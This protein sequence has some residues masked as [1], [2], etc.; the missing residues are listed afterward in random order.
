MPDGTQLNRRSTPVLAATTYKRIA[1]QHG[2]NQ[3]VGD[4]QTHRNR[5]DTRYSVL[6]KRSIGLGAST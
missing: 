6:C 3:K 4:L 2:Q 5:Y 1:D